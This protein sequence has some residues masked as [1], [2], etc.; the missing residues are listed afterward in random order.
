MYGF[1]ADVMVAIHVG[2]VV[3]VVVGEI[4]ILVG[5]ARGWAWVRN[6]WFR[7]THLLAM[8][9]VVFEELASLRCPLTIWEERLR[10]RAGEAVTGETFIGRLLHSIL[11]YDAPKWVFT[12]GYSLAGL[13]V[14]ATFVFCRPRRPS[15]LR[16]RPADGQADRG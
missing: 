16:P 11:F 4:L 14:L 7:I 15:F 9:I 8:G 5:W 12:L 10:V 1:L 13:V 6:F 2:Y 3:Y